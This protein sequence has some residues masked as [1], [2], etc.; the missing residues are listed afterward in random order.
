MG[1]F[2]KVTQT[3]SILG[4]NIYDMGVN[5]GATMTVAE[6][7]ETEL[8]QLKAQKNIVEQELDAL[9]TQ[10]GKRYIDHVIKTGD[11]AG[12]PTG[13]LIKL[14]SPKMAKKKDDNFW[15]STIYEDIG[16]SYIYNYTIHNSEVRCSLAI[17]AWENAIQYYEPQNDNT[18]FRK[19]AIYVLQTIKY[20]ILKVI[21]AN[22]CS[23]NL[24]FT[25]LCSILLSLKILKPHLINHF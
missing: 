18:T 5:L 16:N 6:Q 19:A 7:E 23:A 25:I 11:L 3:A 21:S 20:I 22:L 13:D 9:Y 12:I 2:D 1:F 24:S 17:E 14:M 10:V 15:L 4:K 8:K